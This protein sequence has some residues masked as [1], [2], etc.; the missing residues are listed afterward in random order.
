MKKILFLLKKGITKIV[1]RVTP[2]FLDLGHIVADSLKPGNST[3]GVYSIEGAL[4]LA[5]CLGS[6]NC[7]QKLIRAGM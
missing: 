6:T 1:W 4:A 5:M 2:D 7:I 3:H